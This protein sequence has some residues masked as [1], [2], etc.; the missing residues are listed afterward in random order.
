MTTESLIW[1]LP[2]PPLA[3]FLLIVLFTNRSKALSHSLA[4]A[5]AG[6]AWLGS[7]IVF[8]RAVGQ[9]D[10]AE[11][12]IHISFNW[13]PMVDEW[14]KMGV[15]IDP[16][17]AVT[18]F[19]V[20][21]TVLMIFIYSVGYHN[22]GQPKGDH[23]RPGLPPHGATVGDKKHAHKVPSVEPM[24]SRFF[25]LISLFAFAMF[26]LVVSD[27]LLLFYIAWEIMGFCS[28]ALIGFWYGKESAR[29]AGVKAFLTTRVGDVFML[30]GIVGLYS[31][32]GSL[33]FHE[34]LGNP[35][36]LAKLA[37]ADSGVLGLSLAGL[38][39][40]LLFIGTVG[41]S[42]QFPLHV[43]LPDAMEG[44]TP[45]SAMI[46]AA[47]MVSAGV[48]L[49]VRTFPLVSAGRVGEEL[50]SAMMVMAFIG[51]FTALFASTIALAQND[52]KRVLAYSTIAQLGYMIAAL[53]VGAYV[54]AVFHLVTHAF[55]KALLFLGS[56]SVIHGMEHGVLHT[57]EKIDPQDMYNMGGLKDK[58]PVTF[59]TFVAGGLALSGFP[60][61][62]A[63]FWSKD[64][65]LTGAFGGHHWWV[66]GTLAVSALLT[67]FYTM[68]QITLTFLGKP[69]TKSAEHAS[70][71]KT[72]MVG[73]LVVLAV[74]AVGAGWAGIP[75]KFPLLGG[76]IPNWFGEFVGSMLHEEA[77]HAESIVP[78][79]TSLVVS[80]GGLYLGY[81]VYRDV[82]QGSP[83]PLA[84]MGFLYKVFKYKYGIDEL[85]HDVFI[86]PAVWISEVFTYRWID[87]GLLDGI[88]EG[89]GKVALT[90]GRLVRNY[91]D[92]PLWNEGMTDGVGGGVRRT[93]DA[94]RPVQSGRVQMYMVLA[95]LLV[96]V[97]SVL[98]LFFA[99]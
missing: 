87:K 84:R 4:L 88:I 8:F 31:A 61:V 11:N 52:I 97:A 67:A 53:G 96:L 95:V 18:L 49:A 24:Y 2:L 21:W 80:L 85:Y 55:F 41:K 90:L 17:G 10:L 40:I 45:V 63:G 34:V 99:A 65:I 9:H 77:H 72:V 39:G 50:T 15:M 59:W 48:F 27:N 16:A 74:F 6:T 70:E 32:T 38:L 58:M 89:I 43:W 66:F 47:A 25:A 42:A 35:D 29:N 83:D 75:E 14:F 94:L 91:I 68:R 20:A 30:L 1:L 33:N 81:M 26:L 13:L 98:F 73:P 22:F 93:G 64:E 78:L 57:G 71:N 62:T 69:R 37:A 12:P 79:L 3:A 23:D 82:K 5:G 19:F 28:Y 7:M 44:P 92:I 76:L 56:G 54:A 60:L 36:T 51:A 46:H 86:R